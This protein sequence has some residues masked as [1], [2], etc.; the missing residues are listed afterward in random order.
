MFKILL[1]LATG[2]V[3]GVVAYRIIEDEEDNWTT[4]TETPSEPKI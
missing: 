1:T 2:I 4:F 3:V